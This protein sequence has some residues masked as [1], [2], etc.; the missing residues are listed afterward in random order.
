VLKALQTGRVDTILV[1]RQVGSE[2]H[3]LNVADFREIILSRSP[4]FLNELHAK[5]YLA[6]GVEKRSSICLLTSANLS[7][8]A[9][10]DQIETTF[11]LEP[12][13]KGAEITHIER[14]RQ[15][16]EHI[17]RR[18]LKRKFQKNLNK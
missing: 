6:M 8:P 3:L 13:F 1:T 18:A 17:I 7:E 16:G 15:L 4:L 11:A 14:I 12:P 2:A 9:L 10:H 5:L